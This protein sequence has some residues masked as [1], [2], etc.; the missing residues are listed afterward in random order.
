[1]CPWKRKFMNDAHKQ[2][3]YVTVQEEN[4][5]LWSNTYTI[6]DEV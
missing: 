4:H 2:E 1:M 6:R 3:Q 5:L